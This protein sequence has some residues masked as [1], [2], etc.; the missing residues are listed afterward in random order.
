[1]GV[2]TVSVYTNASGQYSVSVYSRTSGDITYTATV[3]AATASAKV[4]YTGITTLD[5]K[6]TI[7]V[8]AVALSQVAR[9]VTVSVLVKDSLG[10]PVKT[11]GLVKVALTGVGSLSATTVDTDATGVGTV[12][13]VVG[14]NDLGDAVVTASYAQTD[15][16]KSVTAA[17]TITFGATDSQI[18]IVGKRVTAVTSFSKGKTV[19]F[20]VD[21]IK[22]W[23][24]VSTSDA[25]V[26]LYYNLKMGTHTVSVKISGGFSAVE[27]FIVK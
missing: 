23:S 19:A 10:N 8:T 12:R 25:D 27:K 2:G 15:A 22:K 24:K 13:L 1:M 26:V 16:T 17:S 7:T 4:T 3:G 14:S 18:D 21:G 20:Y 9:T 11:T 5:D 6:G